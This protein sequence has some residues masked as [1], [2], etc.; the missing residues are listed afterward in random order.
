[1]PPF[2]SESFPQVGLRVLRV[3]VV[4]LQKTWLD[5]AGVNAIADAA[6]LR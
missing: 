3:F 4:T 1:M 2:S 5:A 6:K